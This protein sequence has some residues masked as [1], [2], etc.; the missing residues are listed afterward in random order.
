[1]YSRK[2]EFDEYDKFFDDQYLQKTV[3]PLGTG[4]VLQNDNNIEFLSKR[5][6]PHFMEIK[7]RYYFVACL[8]SALLKSELGNTV[9]KVFPNANFSMIYSTDPY[10]GQTTISYRS[11]D[12]RTNVT[13][14][15]KL[16]FG[17][18]HRNASGCMVSYP[19]TNPPSGRLIDS[20]HAYWMLECLYTVDIESLKFL[21][22]NSPCMHKQLANYLMQE[23]FFGNESKSRNDSRTKNGLPAYQEGMFCMRTQTKN[24][25]LDEVYHG[26]V[27]WNYNGMTKT[28]RMSVK[29]LPN[30]GEK[31]LKNLNDHM[32]GSQDS[33]KVFEIRDNK[34]DSLTIVFP[35]K[36]TPEDILKFAIK[37]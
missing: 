9:F 29:F 24:E 21:V 2:Y 23:R 7:G 35:D 15:A 27:V 20:Y 5:A 37:N 12:D 6:I 30:N 13:E 1:M 19:V 4:L 22:L 14:I 36:Y 10:N 32:C 3:F 31:A 33:A 11:L 28:F 17:G 26:A 25:K 34:N 18:G 16:N 8:N